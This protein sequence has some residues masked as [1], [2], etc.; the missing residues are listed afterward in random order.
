MG[1]HYEQ[2]AGRPYNVTRNIGG[3]PDIMSPNPNYRDPKDIIYNPRSK[4]AS[5]APTPTGTPT[6]SPAAAIDNAAPDIAGPGNQGDVVGADQKKSS[7]LG[8]APQ[9]AAPQNRR[10]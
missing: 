5:P 2:E 1:N 10:P 9:A 7:D 3:L 8:A 4:T 6:P